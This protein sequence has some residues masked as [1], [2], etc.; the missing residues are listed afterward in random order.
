MGLKSGMI[1]FTLFIIMTFQDNPLIILDFKGLEPYLHKNNDT[2]YVINFWATWCGPCVKEIPYFE[3][4]NQKFK[5][6]KVKVIL[7][8]LDFPKT[9]Q[10]VLLPFI[11]KRGLKSE[12]IL[13]NDPNSNE[14]I[15]KIDKDWSGAIPATLIYT[16]A[17]RSFYEKT[18]TYQELD[19]LVIQKSTKQ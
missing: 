14:W 15:T 6:K 9:Y 1:P 13:L 11:E 4:L 17:S 2:C 12:I 5:D 16:K 10:K 19:S 7:V 3:Q 8:S 18:F